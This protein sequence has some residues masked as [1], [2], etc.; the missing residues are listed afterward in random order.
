M[1][2]LL[3]VVLAAAALLAA[4][5]SIAA[6]ADAQPDFSTAT[7]AVC[8]SRFGSVYCHDEIKV[9]CGNQSYI[10]PRTESQA[11]CGR[12][13]IDLPEITGAATF[14]KDWKDPR[15]E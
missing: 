12:L 6:R 10:L 14:T 2:A 1:K 3:V 8:D 7:V 5:S 11:S 13:K 15:V 4:V 9:V